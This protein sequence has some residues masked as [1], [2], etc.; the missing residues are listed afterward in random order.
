MDRNFYH[1]IRAKE[2]QREISKELANRQLLKGVKREPLT[3][4][5]A[6]QLVMR[7][8]PLILVVVA[9]LALIMFG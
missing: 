9:V 8:A 3:P 7:L 5:R 4:K 6:R 2:F 1:Q